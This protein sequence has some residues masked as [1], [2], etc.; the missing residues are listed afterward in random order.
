MMARQKLEPQ[1]FAIATLHSAAVFVDVAHIA[2]TPDDERLMV[3]CSAGTST[4]SS[5][6]SARFQVFI[7]STEHLATV[8]N[9]QSL[10]SPHQL[11]ASRSRGRVHKTLGG[12]DHVDLISPRISP[13]PFLLLPSSSQTKHTL[14]MFSHCFLPLHIFQDFT[15]MH[16][17]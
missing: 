2:S 13:P 10:L 7:T 15:S 4:T 5:S 16:D 3:D 12:D 9:H 6:S 1:K 8:C 17:T 14:R 11:Q